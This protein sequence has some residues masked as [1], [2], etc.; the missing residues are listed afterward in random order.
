VSRAL[1]DAL[2]RLL[3][4]GATVLPPPWR[5]RTAAAMHTLGAADAADSA[6]RHADR[7]AAKEKRA[8]EVRAVALASPAYSVG[9]SA[10][11]WL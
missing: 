3:R 4:A 1:K 8:R 2:L 11:F 9:Q 7:Q 5:E 10:H 6:L